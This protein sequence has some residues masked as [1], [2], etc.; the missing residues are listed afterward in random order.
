M[1]SPIDLYCL[2]LVII[3]LIMIKTRFLFYQLAFKQDIFT[4]VDKAMLK[5]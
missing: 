4:F 5:C 1:F 2:V 3:S